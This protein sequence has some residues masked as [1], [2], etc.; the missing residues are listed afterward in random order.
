MRRYCRSGRHSYHQVMKPLGCVPCDD[1]NR[2]LGR[3][4]WKGVKA[5]YGVF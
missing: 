2:Y 5:I 4:D 3:G 1:G